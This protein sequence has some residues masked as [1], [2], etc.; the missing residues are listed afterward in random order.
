MDGNFVLKG[1]ERLSP[2]LSLNVVIFFMFSIPSLSFI[3]VVIRVIPNLTHPA[4]F[5][6]T[7]K[8]AIL[9]ELIVLL[10]YSGPLCGASFVQ[11][12]LIGDCGFLL[13]H[14][15]D[16]QKHWIEHDLSTFLCVDNN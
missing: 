16:T 11:L 5:A 14:S 10:Y 4:F 8:C 6:T 7:C 12:R 9:V 13:Q 3:F 1:R 15:M 2:G